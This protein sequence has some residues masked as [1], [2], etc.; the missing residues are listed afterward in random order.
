MWEY[1]G[2]LKLSRL[3]AGLRYSC[4][5]IRRGGFAEKFIYANRLAKYG[6]ALAANRDQLTSIVPNISF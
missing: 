4:C 1:V 5:H 6:D 2:E 3:R